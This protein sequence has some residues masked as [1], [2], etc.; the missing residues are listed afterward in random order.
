MN[1]PVSGRAE[2][3]EI[4]MTCPDTLPEAQNVAEAQNMAT[5]LN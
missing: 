2:M 5:I 4:M 1:L 3:I